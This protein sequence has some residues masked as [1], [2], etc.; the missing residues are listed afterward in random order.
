[1]AVEDIK[2]FGPVIEAEIIT[3]RK[4]ETAAKQKILNLLTDLEIKKEQIV[5]KSVT[6]LLMRKMSR[7]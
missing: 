1:M 5:K 7:F 4:R 6:N 2:N 3:S